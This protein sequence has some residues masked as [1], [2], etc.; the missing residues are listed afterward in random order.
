[1]AHHA[2][3]IELHPLASESYYEEYVVAHQVPAAACFL[4]A[5]PSCSSLQELSE[6]V[7]S[8]QKALQDYLESRYGSRN[9]V[10]RLADSGVLQLMLAGLAHGLQLLAAAGTAA[11]LPD[12]EAGALITLAVLSAELTREAS[13]G[14]W[15]YHQGRSKV[16][17]DIENSGESACAATKRADFETKLNTNQVFLAAHCMLTQ[18]QACVSVF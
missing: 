15:C 14:N 17:A 2:I 12:R 9:A 6:H 4:R 5:L 13:K 3:L 18:L 7:V 8:S 10:Q 11:A 1:M 16:V